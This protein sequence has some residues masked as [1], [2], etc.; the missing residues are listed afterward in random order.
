MRLRAIAGTPP[1]GVPTVRIDRVDAVEL[2]PAALE[3]LAERA[4]HPAVFPLEEPAHRRRKHDGAS[5]AVSEDE[6]FHIAPERRAVPAMMLAI[7][8]PVVAVSSGGK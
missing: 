1:L 4:D 3:L 2:E 6:H 5:A 8:L 7:H